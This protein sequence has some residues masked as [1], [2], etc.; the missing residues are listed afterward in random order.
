MLFDVLLLDCYAASGSMVH[1][2]ESAQKFLDS[3]VCFSSDC[4][5][6]DLRMPETDGCS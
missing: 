6:F 4:L 3:D 5:I 2:Y 1:E